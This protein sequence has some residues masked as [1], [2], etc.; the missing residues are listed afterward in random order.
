[1][2]MA[3][4]SSV[5]VSVIVGCSEDDGALLLLILVVG[6]IDGT[7][8]MTT[9][10]LAL[11]EESFGGSTGL[12]TSVGAPITG[13]ELGAAATGMVVVEG[14]FVVGDTTSSTGLMGPEVVG[15]L[16]VMVGALVRSSTRVRGVEGDAVVRVGTKVPPDELL[17]I[18]VGDLVSDKGMV[19]IEGALVVVVVSETVG[20]AV[21]GA[22]LVG[23]AVMLL[24][25]AVGTA[26]TGAKLVGLLVV[27]RAVGIML[28]L[29]VGA[30]VDETVG[31]VDGLPVGL[32]V[33]IRVGLDVV[34]LEDG[35]GVVIKSSRSQL[36]YDA[37]AGS[38]LER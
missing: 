18:M 10:G 35:C 28:G 24:S 20:T 19:V 14:A 32:M 22:K 4:S 23:P 13:L 21:T 31:E 34:G 15:V 5:S 25:A 6:A 37:L 11:G 26:V 38:V 29:M 1:M 3:L 36:S 30:G 12:L 27:T 7:S 17:L 9:A 33:G 2:L 16:A 8:T